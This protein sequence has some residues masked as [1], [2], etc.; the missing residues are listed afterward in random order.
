MK[1]TRQRVLVIVL[2]LVALAVFMPAATKGWQ[3]H[4]AFG[5]RILRG[6]N[7]VRGV[8]P[9]SPAAQA[10]IVPGDHIDIAALGIAG[11]LRLVYPNPGDRLAFA[12]RHGNETRT[13]TL[14]AGAREIPDVVRWLT[15]LEFLSTAAFI[16]VGAI[17]VFF[18][19]APMTW[20]LWAYCI[21]I[22][23][24]NELLDYYSFLPGGALAAA[25]LAGRTL[26]GG[27]SVFPLL[28][29]VLRFPHD[30]ISGWRER[31]R[32]PAVALVVVI[33][34]YYVAISW[35]GLRYGIDDYSR[36]NGVPALVMYL[37]AAT[38]LIATY[39]QAH[40]SE[41]QRLK[42]AV[43][44]MMIAFA[45]QITNYIPGS[46]LLPPLAEIVSIV[47]PISVAYAALRHR[48]IDVEFVVNRAIVYGGLTAML[49]SF[50]SLIDW[51]TSR[52]I[53]EYHLA[54]YAEAGATIAIG[55]ALDRL[56]GGLED[57]TD[58]FF[59]RSRHV[60]EQQL[61]RV[62]QS[63]VFATRLQSIEEALVDEPA[64]WLA[65]ASA[66]LFRHDDASGTFV[67]GHSIG[68]GGD[69][70]ASFEDDA[71]IARYLHAE[72]KAI[73]AEAAAWHVRD[74]PGGAAAPALYVPIFSRN[75]LH[76]IAVYGAHVNSALPDPGE[77]AMIERLAPEASSAFDHLALDA[78]TR[79][80]TGARGRAAVPLGEHVTG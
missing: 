73:T 25:W 16:I 19:A 42:W 56:H 60:A 13:V 70:L 62:A 59:F 37:A 7:L 34:F 30:R 77:A 51:L 20:W 12:I 38:I 3:T 36:L 47:M 67:R 26:L 4:G 2:S 40:G 53:S 66:A 5:M 15:V 22:V 61:E 65:L 69:D 63:L 11:H 76:A 44:G 46:V 29:F 78:L 24:I 54:L 43:V 27:F 31:I 68:W 39:V 18:R 28:P 41:R 75:R 48:L 55:F 10:G 21:G 14:T 80:L 6:E 50:V 64:R 35:I 58:R 32:I 9:G 33:F 45:A 23:P 57:I 74:L 72:R 1:L 52:F 71:P 49:L 79:Q 8:D 17:L